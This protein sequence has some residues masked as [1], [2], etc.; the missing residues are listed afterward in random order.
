MRLLAYY[1]LQVIWLTIYKVRGWRPEKSRHYRAFTNS[2]SSASGWLA[3]DDEGGD[4]ARL[5]AT[6]GKFRVAFKSNQ[7]NIGFLVA[8]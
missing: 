1:L 8:A 3:I 4:T 7:S 6:Q 2:V 5:G